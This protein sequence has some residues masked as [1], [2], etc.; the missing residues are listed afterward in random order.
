MTVSPRLTE[1]TAPTAQPPAEAHAQPSSEPR[2][3][4]GE[5]VELDIRVA[6]AGSRVPALLIDIVIQVMLFYAL[7]M[8]GGALILLMT[9]NGLIMVDDTLARGSCWSPLWSC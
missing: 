3:V 4:S 9:M 1:P 6:R 5:A 8:L 7:I 2:V